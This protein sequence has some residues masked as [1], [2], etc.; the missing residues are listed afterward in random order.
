L[1]RAHPELGAVLDQL[2][3]QLSDSAMTNLNYQVDYL[4]LE[5]RAVALAWLRR[6]GL[7]KAPRPLPPG[8]AVVRLGSKIFAE[9]YILT[10]MYAAL[11]RGN[12]DL[13]VATKTGL[14]GTTSCFEALRGG[15]IDIYSEPIACS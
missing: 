6:R 7:W 12:T 11:I 13:A 10:E 8:A 2:S 14:G 3:G 4:H 1:L 5:P 9:Q 15:Q